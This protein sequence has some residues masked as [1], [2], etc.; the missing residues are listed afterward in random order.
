MKSPT[1]T[2]TALVV[3][4]RQGVESRSEVPQGVRMIVSSR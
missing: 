3:S 4:D 2:D 1:C